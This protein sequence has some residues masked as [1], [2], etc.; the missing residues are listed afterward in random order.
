MAR[1]SRYPEE[2]DRFLTWA[3]TDSNRGPLPCK[4]SALAN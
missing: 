1:P 4:G 3:F 2:L